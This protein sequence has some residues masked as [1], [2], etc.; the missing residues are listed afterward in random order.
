MTARLVTALAVFV[1]VEVGVFYWQHHDVVRL[2]MGR[3]AVLADEAFP[4]TARAVLSRDRVSRRAR[5]RRAWR[6]RPGG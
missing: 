4:D 2:S 1:L 3:S 6:A 5:D